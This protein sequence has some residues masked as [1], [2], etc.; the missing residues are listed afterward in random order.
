MHV[1]RDHPP[2]V[3]DHAGASFFEGFQTG[4]VQTSDDFVALWIG[5]ARRRQSGYLVMARAARQSTALGRAVFLFQGVLGQHVKIYHLLYFQKGK[6]A[7]S[8]AHD[9]GSLGLLRHSHLTRHVADAAVEFSSHGIFQRFQFLLDTA[10]AVGQQ[11]VVV[12]L[13][14]ATRRSALP[15]EFRLLPWWRR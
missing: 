9:V 2:V 13:V 1:G 5:L 7:I 14:H 4:E 10:S 3:A 6:F 15:T 12:V 8:L 11:L